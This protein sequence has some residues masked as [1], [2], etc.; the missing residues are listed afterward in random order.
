MFDPFPLSNDVLTLVWIN[1]G[2]WV[3]FIGAGIW[4]LFFS[5]SWVRK[6]EGCGNWSYGIRL[7]FANLGLFCM[8]VS[9]LCWFWLFNK[10]GAVYNME[11]RP[12]P[13][14][15][16]LAMAVGCVHLLYNNS[17]KSHQLASQLNSSCLGRQY[18]PSITVQITPAGSTSPSYYL[19]RTP[20]R[21]SSLW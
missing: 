19:S 20:C 1:F 13:G 3:R 17:L 9:L 10:Q 7:Y 15:V 12:L 11:N 14:S 8:K 2:A 6:K 4:Q 21:V 16:T 18:G 5:S